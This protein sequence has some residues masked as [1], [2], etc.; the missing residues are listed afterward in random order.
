MTVT[1]LTNF[2]AYDVYNVIIFQKIC[3]LTSIIPSSLCGKFQGNAT[4]G[5]E[6]VQKFPNG[7]PLTLYGTQVSRVE[8]LKLEGPTIEKDELSIL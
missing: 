4:L 8:F 2:N 1:Y 7:S 3:L 5:K 6:V